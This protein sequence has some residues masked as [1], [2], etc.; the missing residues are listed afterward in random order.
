MF[1]VGRL[2]GAKAIS[3]TAT[4]VRVDPALIQA[5]GLPGCAEQSTIAE[6]L[7]AA[8]EQDVADLQAAVGGLL[9]T[10]SPAG[11]HDFQRAILVL[12][13]D[14]SPLPASA[15]AEGSERGYMGRCRWHSGTQV[16]AGTSG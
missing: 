16:S 9:R 8:T 12:D 15:K 14:L 6:T 2:S 7:N 11:Q 13:G 4:T 1:L 10:A 5:F 3:H